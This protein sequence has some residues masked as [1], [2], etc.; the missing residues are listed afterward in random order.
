MLLFMMKIEKATKPKADKAI[1]TRLNGDDFAR[2]EQIARQS[3]V[4]P[5][6]LARRILERAIAEGIEIN[7]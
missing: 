6:W 5:S 1:T 2:L 4:N 3:N 7:G